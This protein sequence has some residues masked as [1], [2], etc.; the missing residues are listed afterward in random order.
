[1]QRYNLQIYIKY[2]GTSAPTKQKAFWFLTFHCP[3]A[4]C[5]HLIDGQLVEQCHAAVLCV[6]R[7]QWHCHG[8]IR[9]CLGRGLC[10]NQPL[11]CC[12]R[13]VRG[14][15]QQDVLG[16]RARGLCPPC[17]SGLGARRQDSKERRSVF[18]YVKRSTKTQL[19]DSCNNVITDTRRNRLPTTVLVRR[20]IA[21]SPC[22]HLP[23]S[24]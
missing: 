5:D 19:H 11:P 10:E 4:V 18:H 24:S 14:H 2:S 21:R 8:G 17:S 20:L 23:A 9:I 12:P 3:Y 1:M 7:L 16:N 22:C 13:L 15:H 6:R